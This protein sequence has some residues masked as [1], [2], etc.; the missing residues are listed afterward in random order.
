MKQKTVIPSVL[1]FGLPMMSHCQRLVW[2]T[3]VFSWVLPLVLGLGHCFSLHY[4][5]SPVKQIMNQQLLDL[6]KD[7]Q[8]TISSPS[9]LHLFLSN[10][11]A[12]N[13]AY[14]RT[15]IW[16]T[17]T[18]SRYSSGFPFMKEDTNRLSNLLLCQS[19]FTEYD[20]LSFQLLV[21]FYNRNPSVS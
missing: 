9:R 16:N 6:Q 20:L 10:E 15:G 8:S 21:S 1:S 19:F 2:T 11:M 5:A 3:L 7:D 13:P 18:C 12:C 4:Q 17:R 14:K